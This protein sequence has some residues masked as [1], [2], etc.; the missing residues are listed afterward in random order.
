MH[1]LL[2]GAEV[3]ERKEAWTTI[4]KPM[5]TALVMATNHIDSNSSN[6]KIYVYGTGHCIL[7]MCRCLILTD[8]RSLLEPLI[9]LCGCEYVL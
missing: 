3:V 9:Y 6:N 7:M 2:A 8:P 4:P 5:Y 1:E